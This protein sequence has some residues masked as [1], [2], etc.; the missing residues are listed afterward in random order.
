MHSLCPHH[1][2]VY[3]PLSVGPPDLPYVFQCSVHFLLSFFGTVSF[4][5]NSIHFLVDY[6]IHLS[7]FMIQLGGVN[8]DQVRTSLNLFPP[9]PMVKFL[10]VCIYTPSAYRGMMLISIMSCL[11]V[12]D[13]STELSRRPQPDA[14][15]EASYSGRTEVLGSED[16]DG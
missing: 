6:L 8:R 7:N 4:T 1:A 2:S 16:E 13:A 10:Q 3:A 14:S 9:C 11:A 15:W 12:E 5:Y